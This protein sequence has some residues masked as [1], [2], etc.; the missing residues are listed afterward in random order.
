MAHFESQNRKI[1]KNTANYTVDGLH[2]KR[3]NLDTLGLTNAC[4][5]S[6]IEAQFYPHFAFNN[7]YGLQ[8]ITEELYLDSLNNLTKFGGC[9]DLINECRALSTASDSEQTGRNETVNAACAL[10]STYC[11]A[12]VQGAYVATS[13]VRFPFFPFSL[14]SLNSKLKLTP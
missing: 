7:T 9:Y 5:D 1:P 10:A 14:R 12:S 11:F 13:G 3:I 6:Q 2:A 8:T 4:V